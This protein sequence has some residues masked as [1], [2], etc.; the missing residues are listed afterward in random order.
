MAFNIF[1]AILPVVFAYF[2]IRTRNK[3]FKIITGI[4]WLL[5][6]PNSIYLLTDMIHLIHQW[7]KVAGI[8]RGIVVLQFAIL[9]MFGFVSFILG[10]RPFE[11]ILSWL[12]YTKERKV[13]AIILFNFMIAFGI[14]LGR[15][16]RVNSWDVFANT[17][18]VIQA[19]ITLLTSVELLGLT[20][21]FG[22]F[23]N[24]FY[25]LFRDPIYY[26]AIRIRNSLAK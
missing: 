23:C 20:V 14:V 5:F 15:V 2:S 4:L 17:E 25:F 7:G 6:L 19:I 12:K 9:Q 11:H 24:F 16:E 13:W 8:E 22:L 26:S 18:R 10:F 3:P 21:L 1:L